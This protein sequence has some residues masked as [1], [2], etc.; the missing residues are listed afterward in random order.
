MNK[1]TNSRKVKPN[2]LLGLTIQRKPSWHCLLN[3]REWLARFE[4][5]G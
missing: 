5:S 2:F 3:S 4:V 1:S